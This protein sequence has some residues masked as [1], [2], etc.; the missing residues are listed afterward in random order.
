MTQ[1]KYIK[2]DFTFTLPQKSNNFR[3]SHQDYNGEKCPNVQFFLIRIFPY[4]GRIQRNTE[5]LSV[6]TPNAEKYGP[7]KTPYL[8]TFHAVLFASKIVKIKILQVLCFSHCILIL[9]NFCL[10]ALL[11]SDFIYS[12]TVIHVV[13]IDDSQLFTH[14]LKAENISVAIRKTRPTER[15]K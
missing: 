11:D 10:V 15:T 13:L 4:S 1:F 6:F 12:R 7:E 5:Y 2:L 14:N 9:V 8:D 3:P